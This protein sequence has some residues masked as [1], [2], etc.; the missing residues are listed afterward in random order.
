MCAGLAT[1]VVGAEVDASSSL[2]ESGLDSL[3]AVELRNAMAAAFSMPI[4]A[5]VAFDYPTLG[6]IAQYV[7]AHS[8]MAA[9]AAAPEFFPGDAAPAPAQE[10]EIVLAAVLAVTANIL[11]APIT[12]DQPFMEVRLVLSPVLQAAPDIRHELLYLTP[13]KC[14]CRGICDPDMSLSQPHAL[15]F[16]CLGVLDQ[17]RTSGLIASVLLCYLRQAG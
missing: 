2:M 13:V 5:T 1:V 17:V 4:P 14:A 7:L 11:Q 9:A 10:P 8:D 12:P 16:V 15:D 3:G 6:Q